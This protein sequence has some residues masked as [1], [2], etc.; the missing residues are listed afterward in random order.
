MVVTKGLNKRWEDVK[1]DS[2]ELSTLAR[3]FELYNKTEGKSPKTIVWYNQALMLFHRFLIKSS[4]SIS[5]GDLHEPEAREFILYLQEKRRWGDNPYVVKNQGNLAPI[6]IQTHIRALR[7]FFNWLYSEGYT[8]EHR[9]ARL[10][11][12]KAP[13]KVVEVLTQQEIGKILKCFKNNTA[14]GARNYAIMMLFLDTGLRCSELR[15]FGLEDINIEGGY[16]KVMGKGS[17]ER[18]VPF[19]TS[20]QRALLRYALHFRPEPF[21]PIIK[22][23]FLT[24]EGTPM[25]KNCIKMMFQRIAKKSG[26]KRLHPH[27]CRHTFATSYLVN[28]GDVFSLRQILGHTTLEMVG[29]YVTL[30][31]AHVTVQ[32]RKFSPMDRMSINKL[33]K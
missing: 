31:S 6:T 20:T 27:L 4:K 19:G 22:N 23:F 3:H 11:P 28:G 33:N 30:A 21:N 12:P 26:V 1:K 15:N 2:I 25:T 9:L 24:L 13:I 14:A 32:H 10:K 7:G 8:T 16:L 17:K 29:R 18:V 5:L